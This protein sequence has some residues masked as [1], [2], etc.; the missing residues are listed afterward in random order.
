[1]RLLQHHQW[2]A[3]GRRG[4]IVP[5]VGL[6]LVGLVGVLAMVMD[7]GLMTVYR[8]QLQNAADSAAL[9]GASALGT[10]NLVRPVSYSAQTTDLFQARQLAQKFAQANV[11]NLNG[12]VRVVLDSNNDVDGGTLSNP[13]D[14][15]QSFSTSQSLLLNSIRVRTYADATH[16]GSVR[17][18]FAPVLN[19]NSSTVA[20]TAT[21][22][23]E[24]H[25][26][27]SLRPNPNLRSPIL[28]ITMTYNDWLSM[29]SGKTNS[30]SYALNLLT[31]KVV[32]GSDG[33]DEQQLY[34]S[35]NQAPSNK[36]LLRFGV[37]SHSDSVLS[38]QI[39]N[40]PTYQQLLYQ[41]PDTAG[42]PAWSAQHTLQIGAD[43]GWRATNFD[44]LTSV[45]VGGQARLI[46]INNG[47]N[48]GNGANG[49][50]TIVAFAPV[51]V[52]VSVK[53][54]NG[55]GYARVQPAVINDPT[56]VAGGLAGS[57]EGGVPIVRLTR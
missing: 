22:T 53:G 14:L 35:S 13:S 44:D 49:V 9:A 2:R 20:T 52:V 28:P 5:L 15:S 46:P 48:P 56:V 29:V 23:V 21:A 12:T 6:L 54:G 38:D 31:G 8:A 50:Y 45:A 24:L 11:M 25:K 17:F 33:L 16:S 51:R 32:P 30:D 43:P 4:V 27:E 19:I 47:V 7:L 36:G 18:F 40:G 55:K 34:P 41:W 1:M 37:G 10:D 26:I 3:R 57:G 39:Q 42:A